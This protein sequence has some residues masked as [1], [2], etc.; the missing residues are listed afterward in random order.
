LHTVEH[1]ITLPNILEPLKLTVC[2]Q[3]SYKILNDSMKFRC[4]SHDL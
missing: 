2:F 3:G 1:N 4:L